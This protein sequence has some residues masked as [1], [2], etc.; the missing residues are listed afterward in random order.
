MYVVVKIS[1]KANSLA[2]SDS[3]PTTRILL[4]AV[5]CTSSLTLIADWMLDRMAF[6]STALQNRFTSFSFLLSEVNA[7]NT[8]SLSLTSN[9]AIVV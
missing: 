9:L 5:L 1:I 6:G 8:N 3:W 4:V 2:H 7:Q